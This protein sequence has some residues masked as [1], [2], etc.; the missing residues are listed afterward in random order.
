MI[1]KFRLFFSSFLKALKKPY[2][3][4]CVVEWEMSKPNSSLNIF[5]LTYRIHV[6]RVLDIPNQRVKDRHK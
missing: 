5:L 3:V 2:K 6:S 1:V 4:S